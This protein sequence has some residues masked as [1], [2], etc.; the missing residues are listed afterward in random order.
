[1]IQAFEQVIVKPLGLKIV[2]QTYA[3][4]MGNLQ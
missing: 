1:M 3:R 4:F 2:D